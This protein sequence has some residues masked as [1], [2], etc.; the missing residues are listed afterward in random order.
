MLCGMLMSKKKR[1]KNGSIAKFRWTGVAYV[2]PSELARTQG[3]KDALN[4]ASDIE[5]K[6]KTA[7]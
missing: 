4:K 5:Q 6:Q 3:F 7:S 1:P 2:D